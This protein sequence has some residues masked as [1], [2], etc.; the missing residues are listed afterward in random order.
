MNRRFGRLPP[1]SALEGFEAAARL[2]SF[3]LAAEELNL[4]QSAVSHQIKLLE[5]F[6]GM[7]LFNRVGRS[8][9][10]TVA[11]IDFLDTTTQVL[12]ELARGKRR[13]DFYFRP[14]SV[15]WG[16]NTGFSS[17]WLLP[18]YSKL[19]NAHPEIEPWLYSDDDF[20]DLETQEVDL[21]IWY[22][23]GSWEG[24]KSH[25]LFH[26]YLTPLYA[27][28][29]FKEDMK[30]KHFDD[31]S[32]HRLLHDERSE[33]WM[34]WFNLVEQQNLISSHGCNFSDSGL[35]LE[36]AARGQGVTLGSLVLADELIQEAKLTQPFK[37]VLT[38]QEA[39]YLVEPA[40]TRIR[41]AVAK[42]KDW[43]LEEAKRFS[44]ALKQQTSAK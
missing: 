31:L 40:H 9:E 6:F 20:F 2:K 25:K 16:A 5:S 18:R 22:G 32:K 44:E 41:P 33:D 4:S 39:Y 12:N 27:E 15:V 17:K 13:M 11:G 26:D 36:S 28:Q 19:L 3:S 8:I 30:I 23:D 42:A 35:M 24:V 10:L 21:A 14:G 43:L 7:D 37:T 1:L 38:T 29:S 34:S